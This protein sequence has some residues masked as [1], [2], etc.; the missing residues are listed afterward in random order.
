[1]EKDLIKEAFFKVK[2]HINA[3]DGDLSL[4]KLDLLSVK[5][6]IK[7]LNT[8]LAELLSTFNQYIKQTNQQTD[9]QTQL[10]LAQDTLIKEVTQQ[11]TNNILLLNSKIDDLQNLLKT[12]LTE[13]PTQNSIPKPQ[14]IQIPT[15]NPTHH[16]ES[17]TNRRIFPTH[18]TI[19]TDIPTDNK[20]F[21]RL[22]SNY[23]LIST[24][25]EGVPTDRQTDRQTNQQITYPDVKTNSLEKES[26]PQ[27]EEK[28]A[29]QAKLD[30]LEKASEILAS[31]D[32][33]KK[34]IRLKFKRL[35]NQEILLFSTLY[36]LE[37]EG[38]LVDYPLLAETLAL[39]ESSVRDYVQKIIGKGIPI[40]K[41]K[42]NN[43]KILLSISKDL[44]KIASLDTILQLRDL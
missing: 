20:P 41:E 36:Q 15:Q 9:R 25:N 44:K 31:L 21:Y 19:P 23:K 39:S 7:L 10:L 32:S 17:P 37:E 16:E 22:I 30:N 27:K 6:D 1:M 29:I 34:E 5:Q 13:L 8:S 24:G 18:Q 11:T 38:N 40:E 26:I 43:K 12:R 2:D 42:I 3:V 33:L 4:A 35:T 28:I 14:E